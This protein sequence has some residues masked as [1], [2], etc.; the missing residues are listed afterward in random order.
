LII[1]LLSDVH[2]NLEALDACLKHAGE[3][4]AGRYAFLGDFIG[5]GADPEGVVAA[6]ARRAAEGAVAVKGNHDE[7]IEKRAA[8]MNDATKDSIEWTRKVL[9]TESKAFLASLPLVVC[10]GAMCFVHASAVSPARWD[11]VDSPAAARR[12]AE[13]AQATYTFC[14]HVHEQVLYFEGSRGNWSAFVPRPGSPVP[15]RGNRR[16]LALVG[17][18]G[19]PRDGKPA[20]AYAL[21]D[22][23]REQVTFHRVAYDHLAAARKIRKAGLPEAHALRV[24]KGI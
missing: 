8:Y 11:Y 9:S 1:A 20:A 13:A 2:S 6:V 22:P 5:Y 10:E 24:E 18:V 14:G 15:V 17:S 23:S 16:W 21:F 7:A 4:G 19:Q 12:C 3:N